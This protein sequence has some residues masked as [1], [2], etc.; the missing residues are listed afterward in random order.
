MKIKH[1]ED[2]AKTLRPKQPKIA[3][4]VQKHIESKLQEEAPSDNK[5]PTFGGFQGC[6]SVGLI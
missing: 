4:K 3:H 2:S 1:I 5:Q 6:H